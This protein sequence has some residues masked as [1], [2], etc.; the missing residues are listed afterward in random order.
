MLAIMSSPTP[1][2]EASSFPESIF[3]NNGNENSNQASSRLRGQRR[4]LSGCGTGSICCT[5]TTTEILEWGTGKNCCNQG[6]PDYCSLNPGISNPHATWTIC[7]GSC[8]GSYNGIGAHPNTCAG[9]GI[10]TYISTNSCNGSR[11][12]QTLGEGV[13]VQQSSCNGDS[14]CGGRSGDT[15]YKSCNGRLACTGI[16]EPIEIGTGSCNGR[17]A[18]FNTASTEIGNW[19]CNNEDRTC[20]EAAT[21][22]AIPADSYNDDGFKDEHDLTFLCL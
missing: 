12:C 1:S 10:D 15:G 3:G 19:A 21:D 14:A 2:V 7:E 4:K 18:C 17:S 16:G 8:N 11:S 13:T 20:F 5:G 6:D 9:L 22:Q